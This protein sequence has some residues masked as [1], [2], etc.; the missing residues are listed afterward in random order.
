MFL[1][2]AGSTLASMV[3][4]QPAD[5]YRP[6]IHF[7]P[8]SGFMNDPNGPI[9]R[10]GEYH[11]FYQYNP[12]ETRAGH[13]HWGHAVSRDLYHWRNLPIAL[14]ETSAGWAFSGSA[15]WD[16]RNS[17]MAVIYTRASHTSQ[18]QEIAFSTDRGRTFH[19]YHGNPVLDI[20][21]NSFRDPK[22]FWHAPKGR[23]VMAVARAEEQSVVF[24][25]SPDLILWT[26]LSRFGS[27]APPGANYE[28]PDLVEVPVFGGGTK[29]VLFISI[30]PGAPLG[31]S[32]V[33][34][35]VGD[36]DG[37]K[38]APAPGGAQWMDFGKD[39][40]AVQTFEGTPGDAI[41]IAWMN[42]WQYANDVPTGA[43]RSVMTVPRRLRLRN[44]SDEW[45]LTQEPL[46]ISGLPGKP[47][48][49]SWL[50]GDHRIPS[51]SAL[52]VR[53]KSGGELR[54]AN[55]EGEQLEV[56]ANSMRVTV[57]RSGTAGFTHPDFT[58][59][60]EASLSGDGEIQ[61]VIDRCSLELF[62][63]TGEVVGSFLHFFRTV[64]D[65]LITSSEVS[66]RSL[67]PAIVYP[68]ST[69]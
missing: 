31:G 66:V 44:V 26:E 51:G 40:Y 27:A 10:D 22:V 52:E 50:H 23:W 7:S 38:F 33:Q 63:S 5:P 55:G 57:D 56:M 8:A 42:N 62:A 39:F 6:Q 41:A 67:R 47:L 60:V 2:G 16:P 45:R 13:Q 20:G 37:E 61:M 12:L 54:L 3:R 18:T 29:W 34:Y 68:P 32:A 19:E 21:S 14:K 11:L 65:R 69:A 64:P 30:N 25:A 15:V 1:A 17:R 46:G 28:C 4:A 58:G 48:S 59:K 43:W 49:K 35:F 53:M 36:F 9:F 24:Y